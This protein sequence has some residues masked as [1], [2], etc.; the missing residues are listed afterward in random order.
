MTRSSADL[1]C[2]IESIVGVPEGNENV[3]VDGS[4]HRPRILRTQRLI[5]C[6]PAEIPGVP[7]PRNFSN[8]LSNFTALTRTSEPFCSNSRWSPGRNPSARRISCGTVTWPLL[9]IFGRLVTPPHFT[10]MLLTFGEPFVTD[11]IPH[12]RES[13]DY[14]TAFCVDDSVTCGRRSAL[15]ECIAKWGRPKE[16]K[17]LR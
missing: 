4:S 11:R 1:A 10:I 17:R 9:V 12:V 3:C 7:M 8:G 15:R 16:R 13:R 2:R 14:E 5:P 6:R